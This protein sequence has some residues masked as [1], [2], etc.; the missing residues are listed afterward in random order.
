M[1]EFYKY[2]FIMSVFPKSTHREIYIF[3]LS[4]F[5]IVAL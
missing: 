1:L 5:F 4:I 2:H 3:I